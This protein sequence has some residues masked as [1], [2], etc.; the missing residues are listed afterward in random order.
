[1]EK[2]PSSAFAAQAQ[3][4]IALRRY[5]AGDYQASAEAFRRVVSQFPSY[6]G[7]D[8]AHYLMADAYVR[9]GQT[10]EARTALEQFVSF[11]PN[12]EYR[13]SVQLQLGATR[14]AAGDYAR[15]AVDFTSVLS[16]SAAP[17]VK[18]AATY[19]LALC[20]RLLGE[21]EKAKEMLEAYRKAHPKDERAAE[22]AHQLGTIHEDAGRF[23]DAAREYGHA[24][25]FKISSAL[26]VELRYRLGLCR[27]QLGDDKAAIA[28]YSA[29]A[30]CP[31][32][33]DAY[34]LTAIARSAAI[35]EK[36]KEYSKALAAYRD[37]IKNATDP[38]IVVAARE[39][40]SELQ[41]AGAKQ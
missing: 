4:D 19:N 10:E 13:A 38:D 37:L 16:D 36:R 9:A 32:K 20:H 40:A 1:M 35:Y 22:V 18:T 12:S 6:S 39:R 11:F 34:R 8:R 27:E 41:S 3:F 26:A 5:Q 14:F 33:A 15:A 28:A 25:E 30:G 17:E 7:A 29:A 23:E 21:P 31:N 2:Y 24:L